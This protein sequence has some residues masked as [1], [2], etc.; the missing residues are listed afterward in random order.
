MLLKPGYKGV[1]M[2]RT[3]ATKHKLMPKKV[4]SNGCC[5]PSDRGG[6]LI[7]SQYAPGIGGYTGMKAIGSIPITVGTKTASHPVMVNEETHFDVVLGR[8]WLERMNVK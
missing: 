2:S 6:L 3:F 8:Q 4:R 1:Y 7:K 5:L